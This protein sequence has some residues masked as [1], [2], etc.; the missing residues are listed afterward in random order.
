MIFLQ[1]LPLLVTLWFPWPCLS[2]KMLLLSRPQSYSFLSLS[3]MLNCLQFIT[4][5]LLCPL[6]IHPLECF[7]IFGQQKIIMRG[8]GHCFPSS[9]HA[10]K[11]ILFSVN[12]T[13]GGAWEGQESHSICNPLFQISSPV[14]SG[15]FQIHVHVY[16]WAILVLCERRNSGQN[17]L[18]CLIPWS[19][20][21]LFLKVCCLLSQSFLSFCFHYA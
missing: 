12:R 13:W 3:Q 16:L 10:S 6:M 19:N 11:G 8:P 4:T 9:S 21:E 18:G 1:A 14:G 2:K 5:W 20:T 7:V 15:S 17:L